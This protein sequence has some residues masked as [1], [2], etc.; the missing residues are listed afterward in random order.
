[1]R[2]EVILLG[3]A[4]ALL[5]PSHLTA[6]QI[7]YKPKRVAVISSSGVNNDFRSWGEYDDRLRVL[8]WEFDKFR[9]TELGKFF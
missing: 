6:A 2:R 7:A 4:L 5:L 1:M 8:G 9:N 3:V